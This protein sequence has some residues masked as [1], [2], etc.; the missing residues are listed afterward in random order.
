MHHQ[1]VLLGT[2]QLPPG[3]DVDALVSLVL[4]GVHEALP[5]DAGHVEH[6]Q[7][8]DDRLQAGDLSEPHAVLP[9]EGPHILRDGQL[10]GGDEEKFDARELGHGLD[11]GVDGAAV[12]Q[13]P[14]QPY[15]EA[16]HLPPQAGDG[17]E[18][19][20]GLG[21]M[22]VSAVPGVDDRHV[23]VEGG[24]LGG[25]LQG[26]AHD[27]HVGIAGD[28]LDGVLQGL[29]LGHRGGAGV[30][31]AEDRPPHP[32]HGGLEG[33]IGAGGRLIKQARHDLPPAG[34]QK[35]SGVVH[36]LAAPLVQ[37]IPLRSAQVPEIDQMPH[38]LA[39]P[40]GLV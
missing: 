7:L 22:H 30:G 37:S 8:G 17:G 32:Q 40:L 38:I 24:G 26:V 13:V 11:E 33:K 10:P 6:V 35:I 16:V 1:Q 25:P 36:D 29:P 39:S 20:G 12:L 34:V 18:V 2:V 19:G 28:H 27:H 14:A 15:R 31:K 5:L 21:G 4:Q 3:Q 9:Q 23:R